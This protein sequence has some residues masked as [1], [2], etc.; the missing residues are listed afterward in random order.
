M[1]HGRGNI[2]GGVTLGAKYLY[3]EMDPSVDA[4]S[5]ENKLIMVTGPPCSWS[6]RRGCGN[7]I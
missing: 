6:V 1:K 3:E 4:L 2:L 5:P 7:G